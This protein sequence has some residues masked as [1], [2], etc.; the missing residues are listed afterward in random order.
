MK[1]I[2][3][4]WSS[5]PEVLIAFVIALT[6]LTID[7]S[8]QQLRTTTQMRNVI[9][10]LET[11]TDRFSRTVD[12]AFDRSRLNNTDLEDQVNALVD[13][14][15]FA[16]DRLKDRTNDNVANTMDVNAVLRRGMYLDTFMQRSNL[17][18]PAQRAWRLVRNDIDRLARV[19][20][21]TWTW[22]LNT[23]RNSALNKSWTLLV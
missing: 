18:P 8:G 19:Y 21:V 9:S 13:E 22:E 4:R 10:R 7:A 16:T 15:E 17:S 5:L 11:N 20:G 6:Y 14:F 2:K 12:S 3:L 1:I 23:N